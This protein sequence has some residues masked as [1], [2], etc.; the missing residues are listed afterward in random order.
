MFF[1]WKS[2]GC[3]GGDSFGVCFGSS[4]MAWVPEDGDSQVASNHG[5]FHEGC[6]G[7]LGKNKK[8]MGFGAFGLGD[9]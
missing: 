9:P 4:L 7:F 5:D 1:S 8:S 2:K 6:P 3:Q